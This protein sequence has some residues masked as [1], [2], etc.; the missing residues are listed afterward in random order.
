MDIPRKSAARKRNIKRAVYIVLVVIAGLGVT[1]WLRKLQPAAPSVDAGTVWPGTVKQGEM[2]RN[3]R[4]LGTLVAEDIHWIPAV[5]LG[6]IDKILLRPGAE[7]KVDTV[8]IEMS[9]PDLQQSALDA[10]LA[11]KAAEASYTDL[12]VQLEK[13]LLDQQATAAKAESDFA[14]AKMT[15]DTNN[16]LAK[17]GLI[18]D[19]IAKL[20]QITADD[21]GNRAKIEKQR[22]AIS[23]GSIQAQLAV[24]RSRIDQ[25]Q[26]VYKLRRSQLDALKVRAGTNGTLTVMAVEEGQQVTQGANLARVADPTKL[27]AELKIAET[28]AKDVML[29]Q[30]A[31]I[32]TH[33]GL[34]VG[35]VSRK[36]P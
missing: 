3:V 11:V 36:D 13:A 9:N 15:A 23:D 27:K 30:L 1:A 10:E 29:G 14:G 2:V 7:V 24:Q 18:G 8:I 20:S 22:L 25:A 28:S 34:I 5:T 31:S 35:R 4:G 6:K 33:N 21:L 12:K 17:Q 16:I 32:D 26:E 19:L